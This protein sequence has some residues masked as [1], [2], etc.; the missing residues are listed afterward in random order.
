MSV[1]ANDLAKDVAMI[2]SKQL[3]IGD[4]P[5]KFYLFMCGDDNLKDKRFL[6]AFYDKGHMFFSVQRAVQRELEL[7][8]SF[9]VVF[10]EPA[11]AF[12]WFRKEYG[13]R[14][15]YQEHFLYM[16]LVN[17]ETKQS[18]RYSCSRGYHTYVNMCKNAQVVN[19]VAD[20][21]EEIALYDF[22]Y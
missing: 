6:Q 18:I 2:V 13:R 11:L 3:E 8:I 4:G 20:Y 16:T 5:C 10:D 19:P 1:T 9:K 12:E 21:H 22:V 15:S 17:T 14:S 7:D